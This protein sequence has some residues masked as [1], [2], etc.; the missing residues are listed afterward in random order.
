[1]GVPLHPLFALE[2]VAVRRL[3]LAGGSRAGDGNHHERRQGECTTGVHWAPP[4]RQC[5]GAFL[6]LE[7]NSMDWD[8]CRRTSSTASRTRLL[9]RPRKRSLT[10]VSGRSCTS[11]KRAIVPKRFLIAALTTS[12]CIRSSSMG[13]ES[14]SLSLFF[15]LCPRLA[16]H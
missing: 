9:V 1:F 7:S 8:C 16:D 15:G 4:F 14:N 2:N 13:H 3:S 11:M 6:P 10:P 12:G 5:A